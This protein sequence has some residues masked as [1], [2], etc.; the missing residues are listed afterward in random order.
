MMMTIDQATTEAQEAQPA[1]VGE[2]STRL[3]QEEVHS[4]LDSSR[5]DY[6]R[7]ESYGG[8]R[9]G[10]TLTLL[11]IDLLGE[12]KELNGQFRETLALAHKQ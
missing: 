10:A 9:I 3:T 12:L 11:L 4:L 1:P 8:D 7:V 5:R 6:E 2:S